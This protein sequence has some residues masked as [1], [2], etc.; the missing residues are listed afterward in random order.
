MNVSGGL[1]SAVI[2]AEEDGIVN[3]SG[4]AVHTVGLRG[5]PNILNIS[6]Q[7]SVDRVFSYITGTVNVSGGLVDW[8]YATDSSTVNLSGG[9]VNDLDVEGNGIL[10]FNAANT[11]WYDLGGLSLDGSRLLGSG[12]LSGEW[13]DGT[14]FSTN[15]AAS[16]GGGAVPEPLTVMSALIGLGMI[17]GYIKKRRAA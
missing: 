17:G 16:G 10:T 14:M 4:G 7:S 12:V 2:W 6:G 8:L 9:S 3:I 13:S 1:V 5:G 15:V 11:L